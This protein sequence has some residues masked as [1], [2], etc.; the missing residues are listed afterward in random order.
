MKGCGLVERESMNKYTVRISQANRGELLVVM[1]DVIL[2]DLNSAKEKHKCG[3]LSGFV[4]EL[5][6][7]QRFLCELMDTLDLKYSISHELMRLYIYVNKEMINAMIRKDVTL[8]DNAIMVI[9]KLR[10]S[11]YELSK[12]DDSAPLMQNVQQVY[13]GLTYGRGTLNETSLDSHN[14]GFKA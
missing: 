9:E 13:A 2:E 12:E 1:Y 8:V 4:D 14:R 11:Y 6:H 10:K 5:K 3:N 7:G